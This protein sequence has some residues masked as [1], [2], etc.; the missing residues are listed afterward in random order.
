MQYVCLCIEA[1]GLSACVYVCLCVWACRWNALAAKIYKLCHIVMVANTPPSSIQN[2]AMDS[3]VDTDTGPAFTRLL[4][5]R[6]WRG[7]EMFVVDL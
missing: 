6:C 1:R 4:R 2:S 5:T 7:E 3:H